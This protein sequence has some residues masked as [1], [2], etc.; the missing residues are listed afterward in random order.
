[1]TRS[2]G[3]SI[4]LCLLAIGCGHGAEPPANKDVIAT[5]ESKT[6]S[7][8]NAKTY[9]LPEQ[10]IEITD[11]PPAGS[12]PAPGTT[13][14]PT[15]STLDP[16]TKNVILSQIESNMFQRGYT[17][18]TNTAGPKPDFFVQ[19]SVMKT[20]ST[21]VYYDYWYGYWGGYYSPW[22]GGVYAG[23]APYAVPYVVTSTLG[24]LIIE[25]TDPNNPD[26]TNKKIPSLWVGVVTGLVDNVPQAQIQS[27]VQ[28]GIDQAFAQSPYIRSQQ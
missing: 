16:T 28:T 6:F 8:A 19:A 23:Y 27:R 17:R 21:Q 2:I 25:F 1:M 20:T 22:Y 18:L 3:A 5:V 4:L 10:V 9:Y 7:Y 15:T 13:P 24:T 11:A 14:T 26:T 12:T